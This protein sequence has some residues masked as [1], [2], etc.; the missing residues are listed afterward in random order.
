MQRV[1]YGDYRVGA[2]SADLSQAN[3]S[4]AGKCSSSDS[5]VETN[6]TIQRNE[7]QG[8]QSSAAALRCFMLA[9]SV[10]LIW[11]CKTHSAAFPT[12]PF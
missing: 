8:F 7:T 10:F 9:E 1:I 6:A 4:A 12:A 5:V 3:A 11:C 2:D